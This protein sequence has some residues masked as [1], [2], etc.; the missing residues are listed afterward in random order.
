M[1]WYNQILFIL[2]FTFSVEWASLGLADDIEFT[3]H[4]I[5]DGPCWT[6]PQIIKSICLC[7]DEESVTCIKSINANDDLINGSSNLSEAWTRL[8]S[9]QS[10][11]VNTIWLPSGFVHH[12]RL[13][14]YC[15]PY[16]LRVKK[17]T[18]R[19][20]NHIFCA[21]IPQYKQPLFIPRLVNQSFPLSQMTTLSINLLPM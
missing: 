10:I 11:L 13:V 7:M 21:D 4:G 3:I 14:L 2:M 12:V 16:T 17:P 8:K 18:R 1:I 9:L 5:Q 15:L 19:K 6:L 20:V